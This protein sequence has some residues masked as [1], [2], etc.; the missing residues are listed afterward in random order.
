MNNF[1][2]DGITGSKNENKCMNEGQNPHGLNDTF[3]QL[4]K[5]N[6]LSRKNKNVPFFVPQNAYQGAYEGNETN[7]AHESG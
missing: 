1:S 6:R 5:K 7:I 2:H 3:N 4:I